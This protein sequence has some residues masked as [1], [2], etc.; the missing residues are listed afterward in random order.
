MIFSFVKSFFW[1][2][3]VFLVCKIVF[4]ICTDFNVLM[5]V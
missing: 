4:L 5:F 2:A 3:K 1:F